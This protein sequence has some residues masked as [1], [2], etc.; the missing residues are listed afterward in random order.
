[1]AKN[2]SEDQ[3]ALSQ[4]NSSEELDPRDAPLTH[5]GPSE[6]ITSDLSLILVT[7]GGT[8]HHARPSLSPLNYYILDPTCLINHS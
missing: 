5:Q 1:M 2:D 4:E 7:P 3:G 6:Y 8:V